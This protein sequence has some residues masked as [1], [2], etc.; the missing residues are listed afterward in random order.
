MKTV[1]D[2]LNRTEAFFA[3]RGIEKPKLEA[4]ILLAELLGMD[5]LQLFLQFDRPLQEEELEALREPVQRRAAGEPMAYVIGKREFWS[6]DFQVG[7]GVLIPRPDTETL[8]EAALDLIAADEDPVYVADVCAGTGCVGIAIASERPGARVYATDCSD[9]AL[10]FLRANV[11]AHDLQKRVAVLRGDL[12]APIPTTRP[13]DVIVS[14]PPYIAT[15]ELAELEVARTE[16]AL[17]LDGGPDGLDVYRRLVPAAARRARR[18][19]AVEIGADQGEAV[20]ALFR[21]VGL[22][23]VIVKPDLAKRDRVVVGRCPEPPG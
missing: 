7:P 9:E 19:V 18:A 5:R 10:R 4:Q 20:A 8:V 6:L 13:V 11:E 17:A 14:N 1:L 2:V 21:E 23:D 16:P 12:L 15:A 22:I 3:R